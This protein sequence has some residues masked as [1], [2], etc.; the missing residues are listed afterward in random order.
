MNEP[1]QRCPR[2]RTD[3][4]LDDYAPSYRGKPGTWCR[5][6]RAGY[7]ADYQQANYTPRSI[8]TC[9]VTTC[10]VRMGTPARVYCAKHQRN[11]DRTGDPLLA[12]V[13]ST[14][15]RAV[16]QR[17]TRAKGKASGHRCACGAPAEQW[18]YNHQDPSAITTEWNGK[19]VT[20]SL[21]PGHYDPLC[22]GCHVRRDGNGYEGG[23]LRA[24]NAARATR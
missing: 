24:L 15:Y 16:H 18:S 5:P 6:C 20:Y 17:L 4:P 19:Q 13:Y 8:T 3:R 12:R 22:R 10:T 23:A 1:T 2:C 14:T 9:A 7:M 21:D 11:L